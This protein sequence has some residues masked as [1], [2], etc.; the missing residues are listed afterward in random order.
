MFLIKPK[1]KLNKG[2][3]FSILRMFGITYTVDHEH[4]V[5]KSEG[6]T[7]YRNAE[8]QIQ[9]LEEQGTLDGESFRYLEKIARQEIEI[10]NRN[11]YVFKVQVKKEYRKFLL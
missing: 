11:L 4:I 6:N 9:H 5:V 8:E 1:N 2:I 7:Y 10:S 3:A